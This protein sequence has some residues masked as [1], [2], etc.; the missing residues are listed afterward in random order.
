MFAAPSVSPQ[1]VS[2]QINESMLVIRW[3][4]PPA[5][6]V[7]GILQGYDVIINDGNNKNVV[8]C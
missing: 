5:D 6:K 1:N 3:K 4:A 7:N 2:V 8:S